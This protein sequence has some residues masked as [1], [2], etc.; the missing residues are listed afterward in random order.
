M[1][2][3]HPALVDKIR[4]DLA[5]YRR[6]VGMQPD[7]AQRVAALEFFLKQFDVLSAWLRKNPS[8]AKAALSDGF[9]PL[10][11]LLLSPYGMERLLGSIGWSV[12]ERA[13]EDAMARLGR[14]DMVTF[15]CLTHVT[16]QSVAVQAGP[17]LLAKLIETLC[18]PLEQALRME[19]RHKGGRP[20]DVERNYVVDTL[21]GAW[22]TQHGTPAPSGKTGPF[23]EQCHQVLVE[24]DLNTDGLADCIRRTMRRRRGEQ[25]RARQ[26]PR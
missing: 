13:I 14:G 16:R 10:L 12:D 5:A 11:G 22:E 8:S 18:D 25:A 4:A 3:P 19:K 2:E 15:D 1:S 24:L 23:Y 7:R 9:L 20:Q 26:N 21:A 6:R 17:L